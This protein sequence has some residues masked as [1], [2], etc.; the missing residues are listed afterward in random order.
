MEAPEYGR[1]AITEHVGVMIQNGAE[2]SGVERTKCDSLSGPRFTRSIV[3]VEGRWIF[4][5]AIK[6]I[7]SIGVLRANSQKKIWIEGMRIYL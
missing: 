5:V 6:N 7:D 4:G 1:K 3:D 2:R